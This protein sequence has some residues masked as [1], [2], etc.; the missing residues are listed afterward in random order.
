MTAPNPALAQL[1]DIQTPDAI[2]AWPLA[3]GY[4]LLLIV[5]LLLIIG[6]VHFYLKHKK[7]SLI[8]KAAISELLNLTCT[9]NQEFGIQ[10]NAILKRA[11]LSYLQRNTVASIDGDD[12]FQ[13]LDKTLPESHKG[14]FNKLLSQRYTQQ[15][16]SAPEQQELIVLAQL[17][18]NQSLPLNAP[19]SQEEVSC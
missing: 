2:G 5:I 3:I 17:W 11:V 4:W 1:K 14:K 13:F 8:K 7:Q 12:W 15:G 9:D 6:I 10:V 18:L 19:F 16:L